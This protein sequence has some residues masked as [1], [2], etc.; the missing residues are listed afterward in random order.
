MIPE[1]APGALLTARGGCNATLI[2]ICFGR[3]ARRRPQPHVDR[4]APF[5]YRFPASRDCASRIVEHPDGS[6]REQILPTA[7]ETVPVAL[8]RM[9]RRRVGSRFKPIVHRIANS[10]RPAQ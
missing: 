8:S 6:T 4:S 5:R 1:R 2:F 10:Y 7:S 3:R 9:N